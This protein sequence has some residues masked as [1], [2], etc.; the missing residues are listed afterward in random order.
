M[1][2]SDINLIHDKNLECD[3]I[4]IILYGLTYHYI[5]GR[6]FFKGVDQNH[7]LDLLRGSDTKVER[8]KD[9][10]CATRLLQKQYDPDIEIPDLANALTAA[11]EKSLNNSNT[12]KVSLSITG[13]FDSRILLCILKKL[14]IDIHGYT[15]G[16]PKAK[17]CLLGKEISKMLKV[18]HTVYDIRFDK[19][20]F[21]SA[22]KESIR[23]GDSLCSLHRAHR[24]EAIK[25]ES[26]HADTMFL[27]TMG[28][29]FV[30]GANHDDYIIS[31][32]VYDYAKKGDLDT[33]SK[34]S[35]IKCLKPDDQVIREVKSVLDRQS[36]IRDK[37]NTELHALI[38]IAA[39]LHHRQNLIQYTKYIPHVY[40]PFCDKEYLDV[41]FSSKYNFLH[42][43]KTQN[44]M[45]FKLENPK[46][47]SIMLQYLNKDLPKIPFANG[48]SAQEYLISPFYAAYKAR[49]RKRRFKAP[50]SFPLG[51]WMQEYVKEQLKDILQSESQLCDYFDIPEMLRELKADS[52]PETETFWLKYTC[53]I[54]MYLTQEIFGG[55]A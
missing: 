52:L 53:P 3:R 26:A 44:H 35:K 31:D 33:I 13:G 24:V 48:F 18:D 8:G 25:R 39:N 7:L 14:D 43:R 1:T 9:D 21:A 28:G 5:G 15:Y 36:Y 20:L 11:V 2:T 17:D 34:Y 29:E 41:L 22:A 55:S 4:S 19:D 12:D 37:D 23:V 50:P 49:Y 45:R 47:G 6:T 42:R 16:N 27:G 30:K 10:I 38:E 54:Q 32:F 46:F 40:T 51:Q